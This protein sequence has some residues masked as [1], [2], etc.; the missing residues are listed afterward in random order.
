MQAQ[1]GENE[2]QALL[3]KLRIFNK[4]IAEYQLYAI[5][6]EFEY[7]VKLSNGTILIK[8][9]EL[10]DDTND[11]LTAERLSAIASR[12]KNSNGEMSA[13]QNIGSIQTEPIAEDLEQSK[14]SRMGRRILIFSILFIAIILVLGSLKNVGSGKRET[15][16]QKVMSVEEIERSKPTDFLSASGTYRENFW[17]DK[18]KITCVITNKATVATYKDAVVRV[19][20]YTKTKTKLKSNDYSIYEIFPPNSQKTVKLKIDNYQNVASIGWDVIRAVPI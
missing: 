15:Y 18:L 17:G 16:E 19:T 12:F 3:Q 2:I 6:S 14:K 13:K 8:V 4:E 9:E 1:Y 7:A 5:T 11:A 20:Y 10:Q